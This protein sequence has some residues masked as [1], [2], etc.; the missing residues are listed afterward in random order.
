M[1]YLSVYDHYIY[2]VCCSIYLEVIQ[3]VRIFGHGEFLIESDFDARCQGYRSAEPAE[4]NHHD[5]GTHRFRQDKRRVSVLEQLVESS[6]GRHRVLGLALLTH[7]DATANIQA[8]TLS[9]E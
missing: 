1:K 5:D 7:L 6:F 4:E 8:I 9:V 3:H 2:L